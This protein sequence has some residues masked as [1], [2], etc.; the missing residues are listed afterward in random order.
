MKEVALLCQ[1]VKGRHVA[2]VERLIT[3]SPSCQPCVIDVRYVDGAGQ[4]RPIECNQ[5]VV[6]VCGDTIRQISESSVAS[7]VNH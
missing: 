2:A 5:D 7:P 3:V 4:T 6:G 1:G